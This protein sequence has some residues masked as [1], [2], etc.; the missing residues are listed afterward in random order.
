MSRGKVVGAH[1][2][3]ARLIQDVMHRVAPRRRCPG[4]DKE[5]RRNLVGIVVNEGQ[6]VADGGQGLL[7]GRN[8]RRIGGL[9]RLAAA[10]AA[11]CDEYQ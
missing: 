9:R 2:E 10:A 6:H 8:G 7:D 11:G 4:I 5:V 3:G 1:F